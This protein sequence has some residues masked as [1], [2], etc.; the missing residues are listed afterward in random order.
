[1]LC[2]LPRLGSG[3]LGA[4]QNPLAKTGAPS[5]WAYDGKE[6]AMGQE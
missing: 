6:N 1:M 4:V 3:A 5:G 2:I